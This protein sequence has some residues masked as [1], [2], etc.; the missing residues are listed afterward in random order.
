MNAR[1]LYIYFLAVCSLHA[2]QTPSIA[3]LVSHLAKGPRDTSAVQQSLDIITELA[4][5]DK[6][7]LDNVYNGSTPL[8]WAALYGVYPVAKK[9]CDLGVDVN[10]RC[11]SNATALHA[12][13]SR[14][15]IKIVS[16]L[17]DKKADAQ[18]V[19]CAQQTA[20]HKALIS[21]H[22]KTALFLINNSDV[23]LSLEDNF[24]N[25]AYTLASSAG[26]EDIANI[27]CALEHFGDPL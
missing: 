10:K 8:A 3:E 15:S 18:A 26:F 19:T 2:A 23:A 16:L 4:R 25:T 12:A 7:L 1:I 24:D 11:R 21:K 9:L 5:I 20:L 13:A 14:G 27:I 17:L 22:K 6:N